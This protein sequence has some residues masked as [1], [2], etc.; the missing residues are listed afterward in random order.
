MAVLYLIAIVVGLIVCTIICD[1]FVWYDSPLYR[2]LNFI[3]RN[4]GLVVCLLW[5]VGSL[6]IFYHYWS[7]SFRFIDTIVD[8]S[9]ALVDQSEDLIVL[10]N[11]LKQVELRMNQAKQESLRNSR[12]AKEAEQRKNEM[13]MYLAHDV[14]TPLTS[15]IG[16]LSLL[17][18]APD[19][20]LEQKA[21]YVN[22]TLDKAYRLEKLV[23]EFFEITRYNFQTGSLALAQIDL[24]YMMSQMADEFYPTLE[25]RNKRIDLHIP[26]SITI[27]GDPDKLAR[28]FNNIIKN[29]IDYSQPNTAIDIMAT[30]VA[31]A[32][33]GVGAGATAGTGAG[34]AGIVNASATAGASA[35]LSATANAVVISFTNV[36]AIPEDRLASIF[37]RFYRLDSARSTDSGG[38]GLG[39][40]IAKEI[41]TAHGGSIHAT[42]NGEHTTF[43]VEL[44]ITIK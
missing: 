11:E 8:A 21:K 17:D 22:I 37:D 31:T 36:G 10:P 41:V 23:D 2:V 30:L 12:L 7:K 1:L 24:G 4:A 26:D 16:Y 27:F 39:L 44:P 34:A 40:A 20:P 3:Q 14:K 33:A 35:P 9:E 13:V 43:T 38:A 6:A 29:A 32:G 5:A 42:S 15:V 28:V 25:A 19:M 18:E